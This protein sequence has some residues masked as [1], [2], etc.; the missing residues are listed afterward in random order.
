M[1]DERRIRGQL[2]RNVMK[3]SIETCAAI[4]TTLRDRKFLLFC[5]ETKKFELLESKVYWIKDVYKK[6]ESSVSQITKEQKGR[7][8]WWAL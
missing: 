8:W 5:F 7:K 1:F 4:R 6:E 3:D 2:L